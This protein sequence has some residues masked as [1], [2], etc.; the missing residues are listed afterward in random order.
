MSWFR[1]TPC[2][3]NSKSVLLRT[4]VSMTVMVRLSEWMSELRTKSE[5]VRP[6]FLALRFRICLSLS[7]TRTFSHISLFS[8]R[9]SSPVSYTHLTINPLM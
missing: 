6:T 8:N 2:L 4:E 9:L 5:T 1:F 7:V 3:C